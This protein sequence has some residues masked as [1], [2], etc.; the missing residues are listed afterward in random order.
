MILDIDMGNTR[1]KW[2]IR[3]GRDKLAQGFIGI[4]EPLDLLADRLQSYRKAISAVLVASVVGE[5]LGGRLESWSISY[6]GL[7]PEFAQTEFACGPVRNGYREPLLL[8]V[9][10][11]LMII[12]AYHRV[13]GACIVISCGTAVTL[14]L[15]GHNGE[16]LGGYI[17]PGFGLMLAS[18]TSGARQI[19]LDHPRVALSLS[20]GTATADAV[21][22]ACAAM[23]TGL[24]DNGVRQIRLLDR[25]CHFEMILTGG[26]AEKL[27]SFYPQAR[28]IP[29]LVLDGLAYTLGYPQKLE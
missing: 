4:E 29:D 27:A 14:D 15:I 22:S 8:G 10:R 12:A 23:L 7:K 21:Y 24:I 5:A 19:K 1:L 26:D 25:D 18:L 3:D 28:L 20:P 11:W 16:H 2:R 13:N 6:L 9:D 17:A